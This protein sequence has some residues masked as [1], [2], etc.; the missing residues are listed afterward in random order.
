VKRIPL[1]LFLFYLIPLA[2]SLEASGLSGPPQAAG[3][4]ERKTADPDAEIRPG[5][6]ALTR[7]EIDSLIYPRPGVPL[8]FPSLDRYTGTQQTG[9][10][11]TRINLF[12]AN[13]QIRVLAKE[14]V[15]FLA[16]DKRHFYLAS[17]ATTGIGIAVDP[18][19]G[20]ISGF[21]NKQGSKLE[22]KGNIIGQLLT[23]AIEEPQDAANSCGTELSGQPL[24]IQQKLA[25]PAY[26]SA[27]AA[28]A[29]EV[30]SYEAVVAIDTD[31]EWLDGFNDNTTAAMNWITDIF[32]AMN[33]FY[34][35]DVETRLLIGDVTL[36]TGSGDPYS[37][38]SNRSS[39]LEEF[40]AF[41]KDNMGDV[42]RQ[43]AAMLSGRN[44]NRNSFSGI[45]WIDQFCKYGTSSGAQTPGSFSYNAI[46]SNRTAGNIA[47]FL[48]HEIG[49][50]MG[51]PHTHCY[52]PPL[53]HCFDADDN[54]CYTGA[55][56][57]P[58][59]GPGTIMSYCH[60][61]G[62]GTSNSEFHSTVQSLIEGNLAAE[63]AAGCIL[64][65]IEQ[66]PDDDTIFS[67]GFE[68]DR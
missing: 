54:D 57:C 66:P 41:W 23:N 10:E 47:V 22:I 5:S 53:D 51:S 12:A 65:Y 63:L 55:T 1:L 31:N 37:E 18:E 45:A 62:C 52:S 42:D 60:I 59:G 27:S 6:I 19:T 33:V 58:A 16:P 68:T 49:H 11:F 67:Q 29:G 4:L 61:A 30:I 40:G 3:F 25:S 36:R 15:E 14:G 32:L 7:Q 2:Q 8:R 28:E 35:R 24:E 64:P 43:F 20:E 39:Q 26:M 21:I 44:I 46:G 48:G 34:E 50:N 17:N 9:L 13:A 38:P 56:E